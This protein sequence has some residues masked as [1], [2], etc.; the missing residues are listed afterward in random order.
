MR[1]D[2]VNF[3]REVDV[4]VA[5]EFFQECV[6]ILDADF[7]LVRDVLSFHDGVDDLEAIADGLGDLLDL[8]AQNEPFEGQRV[9]D[10]QLALNVAAAGEDAYVLV[11]AR[12][13]QLLNRVFHE[14]DRNDAFFM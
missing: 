10:V 11:E 12:G 1:S 4:G 14:L 7:F 5:R 6:D 3:G 2:E 13:H 9:V 8:L